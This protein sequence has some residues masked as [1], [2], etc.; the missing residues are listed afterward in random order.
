MR[1]Q[2][3]N[4]AWSGALQLKSTV[5]LFPTRTLRIVPNLFIFC[6]ENGSVGYVFQGAAHSPLGGTIT[7]TATTSR[8]IQFAL[9]LLF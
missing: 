1:H 8:Q 2:K 9:K 3:S 6:D 5:N 7:A 4:H